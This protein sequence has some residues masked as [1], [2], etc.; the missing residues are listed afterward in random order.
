VGDKL[1]RVRKDAPSPERAVLGARYCQIVVVRE[2]CRFENSGRLASAARNDGALGDVD[3]QNLS[4]ALSNEGAGGL[5]IEGDGANP[6]MV[7]GDIGDR[8]VR[9]RARETDRGGP[10]VAMLAPLDCCGRRPA[11]CGQGRRGVR[12]S[13]AQPKADQMST[14]KSLA[15]V[16]VPRLR[17]RAVCASWLLPHRCRAALQA[18]GV[19]R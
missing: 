3:E 7:D 19:W 1:L 4:I 16:R 10:A 15:R 14:V 12:D 18:Q 9:P 8:G 5:G 6:P 17:H 11:V 2:P 13:P